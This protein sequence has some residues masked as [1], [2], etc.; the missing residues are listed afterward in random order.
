VTEGKVHL[1]S[2][3]R[4]TTIYQFH[5]RNPQDR[6]ITVEHPLST[7]WK[8]VAPAKP[9]EQ[10]RTTYRFD[11][12][13][14]ANASAALEVTEESEGVES[15]QLS[16]QSRKSLDYFASLKEA[17]PAVQEVFK[18]LID[19]REKVDAAQKSLA[20]EQAAIKEIVD[21][22]DRIRKNIERVPKESDA[23]KR[24]LKK[25]DEQETEIEKRQAR[26]KELKAEIAKQEKAL[27]DFAASA[28]AE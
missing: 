3:L 25:F 16:D 20:E 9:E 19:F 22:Q 7:G 12:R 26:V 13:L 15:W 17:K 21:D 11:V 23:F 1:R 6:T 24:Y 28:K 5:N 27:A 2:A 4:R 18:K 14:K 10:T 8:L